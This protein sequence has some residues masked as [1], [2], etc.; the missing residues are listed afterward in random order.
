MIDPPTDSRPPETVD[1]PETPSGDCVRCF[2]LHL[3]SGGVARRW[4]ADG[5]N[6][7]RD[8]CHYL[9]WQDGKF[10]VTEFASMFYDGNECMIDA[11]NRPPRLGFIVDRGGLS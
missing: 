10:T 7:S 8:N 1:P 9:R 11:L 3:H 5:P 6:E 2:V 4:S